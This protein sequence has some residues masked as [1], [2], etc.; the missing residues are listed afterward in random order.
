LIL[1]TYLSLKL[2]FPASGI[3]PPTLI[4]HPKEGKRKRK[5]K[6]R[7]QASSRYH[8]GIASII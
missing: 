4:Q 2:S 5:R 1:N 8:L 3:V 6:G 7:N